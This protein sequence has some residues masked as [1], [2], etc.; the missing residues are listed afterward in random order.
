MSSTHFNGLLT[1]FA[2]T[3][4]TASIMI[5][6]TVLSAQEADISLQTTIN[7]TLVGKTATFEIADLDQD[8]TNEALISYTDNCTVAGCLFSIIDKTAT[9]EIAEVA[10][11]YGQTP[12]IV[13]EG[14]VINANGV[15]FN[16]TGYTL[17]PYHDIYQSLAFHDGNYND[18]AEIL[19]RA[20][21]FRT[22]PSND[23]R[24]ANVDLIGNEAPE[25]FVWL[26]GLEYK[27][28]QMQPWYVFNTDGEIIA[29]GTFI[30]RPYLFNLNDRKAT[31]II[32][33]NGATFETVILE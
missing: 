32:T 22:M 27:V 30:D 7:E 11:Q 14:T 12:E 24:V 17:R 15:Y 8:G 26:D 9:G 1:A 13:S 23:I 18:R 29:D 25:R 10:Y 31:A 19:K 28:A 6:A 16:W 5:G 3:G 2:M 20:P 4:T 21:W 33:Y